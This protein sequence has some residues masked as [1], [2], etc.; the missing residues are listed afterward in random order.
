MEYDSNVEEV[1]GVG[2]ERDTLRNVSINLRTAFKDFTFWMTFPS[3]Q[4]WEMS[5]Y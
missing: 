1:C 3:I 4:H 5:G 2:S